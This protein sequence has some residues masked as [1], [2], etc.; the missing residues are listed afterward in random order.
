MGGCAGLHMV[1]RRAVWYSVTL[2]LVRLYHGGIIC[3]WSLETRRSRAGILVYDSLSGFPVTIDCDGDVE[4][5]D[6]THSD[7]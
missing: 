1:Q 6:C 2:E 3:E 7:L 5:L 4:A